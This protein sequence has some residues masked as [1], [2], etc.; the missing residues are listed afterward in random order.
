MFKAKITLVESTVLSLAVAGLLFATLTPTHTSAART[1]AGTPGRT[2]L[3]AELVK[4]DS[5]GDALVSFDK[6]VAELE[7]KATISHVEYEAV[8][9]S[10]NGL[11]RRID[12]VQQ[13]FR[14]VIDKLKAAREWEHFDEVAFREAKDPRVR[15]FLRSEGGAKR[16]LERAVSLSS[17][18]TFDLNAPVE[19]LRSRVEGGSFGALGTEPFNGEVR[20]VNASYTSAAVPLAGG[21]KCFF[22]KVRKFVSGVVN[23]GCPSSGASSAECQACGKSFGD[24]PDCNL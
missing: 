6:R 2:Q 18:L 13:A 21:G 14:S 5:F 19:R 8:Q 22:S 24:C 12:E 20:F 15:E 9:T 17:D 7:K 16:I 3:I 11:K 4:I 10:G 1:M 23:G